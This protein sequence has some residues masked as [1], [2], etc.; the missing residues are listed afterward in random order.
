[1]STPLQLK[2]PIKAHNEELSELQ[3]REPTIEEIMEIG[4][5]YLVLMRDGQDT[6]LEIRP[7]VIVKYISKLAGIPLSSAKSIAISDLNQ[8]QTI[9][10]G[11]FGEE[12][13]AV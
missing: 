3:L 12:I 4:Y 9:I 10:M 5:P 1:M 6:G 11:F 7:Q 13:A 2:K 8:A